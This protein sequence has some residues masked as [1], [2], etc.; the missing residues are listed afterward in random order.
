M[1]ALIV[2][3]ATTQLM[4]LDLARQIAVLA[5]VCGFG[6]LSPHA[7]AVVTVI[8]LSASALLQT[9]LSHAHQPET[10]FPGTTM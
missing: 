3:G 10:R 1:I 2:I 5:L 6:W 8:G 4:R 7:P 9:Y